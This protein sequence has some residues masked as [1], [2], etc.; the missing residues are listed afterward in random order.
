VLVNFDEPRARQTLRHL[1]ELAES[2][3]IVFLTCHRR[4]V[5]LLNELK[6]QSSILEMNGTLDDVVIADAGAADA[7]QME[8]DSDD[9]KPGRRA[10]RR[11]ERVEQATLFPP[12]N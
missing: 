5:D 9:R 3:Q 7:G 10:R 1:I 6:P 8:I 4:T 11:S 2:S 12:Q